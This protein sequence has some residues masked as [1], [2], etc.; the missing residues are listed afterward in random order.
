METVTFASVSAANYSYEAAAFRANARK[1]SSASPQVW[2]MRKPGSPRTT[3][4]PSRP[5]TLRPSEVLRVQA[6]L[7]ARI[8]A[9]GGARRV[10][11]APVE[12]V[13][14]ITDGEMTLRLLL[15][16]LSGDDGANESSSGP[17]ASA[18]VD[19]CLDELERVLSSPHAANDMAPALIARAIRHYVS[20]ALSHRPQ[21]GDTVNSDQATSAASAANRCAA[22][23]CV[24][25]PQVMMWV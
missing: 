9:V 20:V 2:S 8:A 1:A 6:S 10:Q 23:V 21:G 12:Q 17:Q 4:N 13:Y 11:R 25:D 7:E 19:L 24:R 18:V 16:L 14:D 5:V 3:G 22:M 15:P